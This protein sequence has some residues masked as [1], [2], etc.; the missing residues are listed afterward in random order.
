VNILTTNST[1]HRTLLITLLTLASGTGVWAAAPPLA[2]ETLRVKLDAKAPG[3]VF[4]GIG[5]VSAGATSVF[6]MDYPEPYRSDILDLLF[7]PGFGASFQ[8]LKVE[9][10]SGMNST[11]GA[12]P[13]HA[14]TPE[15][16]ADPVPRGYELWLAAEARKRNPDIL[17][18]VLPW[19]TPH[20]TGGYTTAEAA[21][22][23]VSFLD[24]A[25]KHYGLHFN[26]VGGY[27]NECRPPEAE[28]ARTFVVEHLRPALDKA[29][30]REVQIVAGDM[31]NLHFGPDYRWYTLKDVVKYPAL[32]KAIGAVGYHYPVGYMGGVRD[33]RP[34]PD[35][36]LE[37][38]VPVWST[39]DFSNTGTFG[40]GWGYLRDIIRAYD[41]LRMTKSEAWA[42]FSSLPDGFKWNQV[43]FLDA[44][45]CRGGHYE[46]LPALWCVA[47]ITQFAKPGWR[48]MDTAQGRIEK[49]ALGGVFT[50]LWDPRRKDW[51]MVLATWK[52]V[53][54]EVE[55]GP[56]MGD[57]PVA[58]WKSNEADQFRMVETVK[59]E[60]SRLK[61]SLEGNHSLYTLT[62][63]TGQVKGQPAHPIPP[64]RPSGRWQDD[65]QDY[66]E[67]A[68]PR[69]WSDQEGTFEVVTDGGRKVLKQVV[70]KPGTV[71]GPSLGA[72]IS[73]FGG[74]RRVRTMRI[75]TEAM[76]RQGFV[77]VGAGR[78][79]DPML[80]LQLDV[81]GNWKL[82][83]KGKVLKEGAAENVA[84]N[85]WNSLTF[86]LTGEPGS[87]GRLTCAINGK[88]CFEGEVPAEAIGAGLVPLVGSSYD[89]NMFRGV[90]ITPVP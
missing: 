66:P 56:A 54:L 19:G 64:L 14:I 2:E 40:H 8:H 24:V 3:R 35:G 34:L 70:P 33:D 77:E 53:S 89:P 63:T 28:Q 6:L 10:G 51:S 16:L 21:Q 87:P 38:G 26:Y 72:C 39:E 43:G 76:V 74:T 9:L 22:W 27:R 42:P 75:A 78:D 50:T 25:R 46:V 73:Y 60:G 79:L 88:P 83:C 44:K 12:E 59:P 32:A 69:Y 68:R 55:I 65:F 48:F 11:C 84:A 36:F 18:D 20:W 67:H 58:V 5:A 29:G 41:E 81:A 7:K 13:S 47:H 15:E 37:T 85:Q 62:T 45:D 23:V 52:P 1:M 17:L 71:W 57:G 4:E 61:V 30:Y 86:D 80:R 49:G 82:L 90:E 31:C